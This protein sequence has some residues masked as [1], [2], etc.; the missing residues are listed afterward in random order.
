MDETVYFLRW[1]GP[2]GALTIRQFR[3]KEAAEADAI[4]AVQNGLT[5]DAVVFEAQS[6]KRVL[7]GDPP[8]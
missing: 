8:R 5:K 7:A 1:Y 6:I 3:T 4:R 2:K